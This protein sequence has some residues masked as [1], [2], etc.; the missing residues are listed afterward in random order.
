MPASSP[1]EQRIPWADHLNKSDIARYKSPDPAVSGAG[2]D[3][4]ISMVCGRG[5]KNV[6]Q[7]IRRMRLRTTRKLD[8]ELDSKGRRGT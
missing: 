2:W 3:S 8:S 4:D 6:V 1:G 5:F 7:D